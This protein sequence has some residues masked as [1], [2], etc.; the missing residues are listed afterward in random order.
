MPKIQTISLRCDELDY[1]AIQRA[2][3]KRQQL[4]IMP[5]GDGNAAGRFV[6]EICRG[7]MQMMGIDVHSDDEDHRE[8]GGREV[9]SPKTRLS[10]DK[11]CPHY[12]LT[13]SN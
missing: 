12:C 13:K 2:I 7:W 10:K 6:A 4:F 3:A 5:D 8:G 1:K 9:H 11:K